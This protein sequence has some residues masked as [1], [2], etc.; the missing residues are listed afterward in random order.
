MAKDVDF[1]YKRHHILEERDGM[2]QFISRGNNECVCLKCKH[3]I[4]LRCKLLKQVILQH[5][6]IDF[7]YFSFRFLFLVLF[8]ICLCMERFASREQVYSRGYSQKE[9]K[10]KNNFIPE[11]MRNIYCSL[12]VIQ[13]NGSKCK[14]CR[15]FIIIIYL[16]L[17][18]FPD[19]FLHAKLFL[20][21]LHHYRSGQLSFGIAQEYHEQNCQLRYVPNRV[22]KNMQYWFRP[23]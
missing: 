11:E 14:H 18:F 23:V 21:V 13:Q 6:R 10:K 2:T 19:L 12:S 3:C 15:I 20:H 8:Q 5:G 22:A 9:E 16:F 4:Y 1:N 7:N 17:Y